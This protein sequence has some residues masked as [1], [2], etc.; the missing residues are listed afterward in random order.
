MGYISRICLL[1]SKYLVLTVGPTTDLK[2]RKKVAYDNVTNHVTIKGF[3]QD[4]PSRKQ[5]LKINSEVSYSWIIR[6]PLPPPPL[7]LSLRLLICFE[8]QHTCRLQLNTVRNLSLPFETVTNIVKH[9]KT[10]LFC[11]KPEYL[12]VVNH[13][14]IA[15][16]RGI[17]LT[18]QV[19]ES[20]IG[21]SGIVCLYLLKYSSHN[22]FKTIL[23]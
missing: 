9:E 5:I 11:Q 19:F 4:L 10:C 7:P 6:F 22:T 18:Q 23:H 17:K 3:Q 12:H 2:T 14:E 15:Q 1:V 16:L 13:S 21:V 20:K 8:L